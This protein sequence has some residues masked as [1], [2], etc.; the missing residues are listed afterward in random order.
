VNYS[1][2]YLIRAKLA[3]RVLR[4]VPYLR[5]AALNGSIVR[6]E[7]TKKSDIDIFIIARAGRLYTC[8]AFATAL[9]H[10]TGW[11]R[12]G[13]RVAGRICLNCYLSDYNPDIAPRDSKSRKKVAWAYKYMIPLVATP[14]VS[15]KFFRTNRWFD[16][17]WVRGLN[18]QVKLRRQLTPKAPA[19][20][21]YFLEFVLSGKFGWWFEKKL[22]GWQRRRILAGKRPGDET[23]ATKFE[24]RL[25]PKKH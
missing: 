14:G 1:E 6:G 17:F 3:G 25:H 13:N 16:R 4:F 18:C 23:V 8:R 24:I 9:I 5:L 12:H 22:M 20:P 7:E 21:E 15:E 2:K 11:R 10:L 19:R